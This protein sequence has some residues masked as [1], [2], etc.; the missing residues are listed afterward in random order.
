MRMKYFELLV[1][2]HGAIVQF[3]S[4]IR[5]AIAGKCAGNTCYT[6]LSFGIWKFDISIALEKD[7][8]AK[9]IKERWDIQE[10]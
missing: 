3:F 6:F 1:H 5:L 9:N 10:N 7:N 2:N 8:N 4:N